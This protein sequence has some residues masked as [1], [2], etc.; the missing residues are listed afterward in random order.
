MSSVDLSHCCVA[1]EDLLVDEV[2]MASV[3]GFRSERMVAAREMSGFMAFSA[4]DMEFPM[5]VIWPIF[6]AGLDSF[7]YMWSEALG[8]ATACCMSAWWESLD[9]PPRML[10]MIVAGKRS[11]IVE[12]G[13]DGM[14][15]R[16][17][18]N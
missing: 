5:S 2:M 10:S 12:F 7:P 1:G 3:G 15:P 13:K 6:R 11:G 17:E 4:S 8:R 9:A 18:S 16:M 14:K